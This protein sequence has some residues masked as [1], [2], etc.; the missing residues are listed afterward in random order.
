MVGRLSNIFF[1]ALES[2]ALDQIK[3]FLQSFQADTEL[4][5]KADAD[6]LK[7]IDSIFSRFIN[8]NGDIPRHLQHLVE[9]FLEPFI[10]T[11]PKTSRQLNEPNN[12]RHFMP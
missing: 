3:P 6:S 9:V 12:V 5:E 8:V 1:R 10:I 7:C 2:E 4:K 11:T